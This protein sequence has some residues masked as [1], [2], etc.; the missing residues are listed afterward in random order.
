MATTIKKA[1]IVEKTVIGSFNTT[2]EAITA[3][4]ISDKSRTVEV[5]AERCFSPSSHK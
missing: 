5:E 3:T 2:I 4:T 1:P